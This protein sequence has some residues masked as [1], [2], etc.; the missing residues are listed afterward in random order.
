MPIALRILLLTL[1]LPAC[2]KNIQADRENRADG[3]P[4]ASS[5]NDRD[6]ASES[7]G[8]GMVAGDAYV[9]SARCGS[10]HQAEF[11]S[12][13]NSHH[14]LAMREASPDTVRGDFDD[15]R[16][17]YF[18]TVSRFFKKDGDYFVRTDGPDG[19][20]HDYPVAYTF[21][22]H[23]LQQYLVEF[24]GGRL[25]VLSIAWDSRD[26][27]EGGQRWF[28]LYPDEQVKH[29]DP[30]HWTGIDQNWNFTCADCHSTNLQKNYDQATQAYS[31]AWS[32]I[33]VACEACHGPGS[34]H[35]R[36]TRNPL[37]ESAHKGFPVSF[38]AR[39]Q[40]A[41]AM[42]TDSGIARPQ[43]PIDTRAEIE[44][45]AQC[46]SRRATRFPGAG[47]GD[48]LLDHFS[49]AVLSEPLYHAD[50]QINGEVYVYGSFLQSRMHAAGVTCSNCH[51][52]HSLQLRA[53]GNALC[54]QC[55]L[56][57][58]FDTPEHHFHPASGPG[59]HCVDCHMP[60][61][62]YMQVDARRDHSFRIPRPDLSDRLETPNACIGCHTDKPNRWAA[63]LLE[64]KFGKPAERHYGE[65]IYAGRRG[66][67]GAEAKLLQLVSD[68]SQ[69]TIARATAVSLLPRYLSQQSAP[70]LQA[71]A[72]GDEPLLSLALAQSLE[73]VPPQIRPALAV[74]LLYEDR[75]VTA[76]LAANALAGLPMAHYPLEVKQRFARA[77][78][79]Y[80]SA[81]QFN[82]DRPESLV[83]LA[84]LRAQRGEFAKAE[85]LYREAIALAPDYSPAYVNLAD[86]YRATG[87]EPRAEALLRTAL[88]A[89]ADKPAIQHALGLSL[90]RQRKTPEAMDFLRLSAEGSA[91]TGR[92]LYVYA[93]ALNST[94]KPRDA[95]FVL[96][97]GLQRF[98]D[99]PEILQG[100]MSLHRDQGNLAQAQRY[101]QRLLR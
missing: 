89:A 15:A 41:W 42:D 29:G 14:D 85:D 30:L 38:A 46:H 86:L 52:P 58:K 61:K 9:G 51:E 26:K 49:P 43:R 53:P 1:L 18:G 72:R 75:R 98:P 88:K 101:Q 13:R 32:E 4:V 92:Y 78:D 20:P 81:E 33:N 56:P 31:T 84:G 3:S 94:G 64:R 65:A 67:P 25:Q 80:L 57:E 93:I 87:R 19:K 55:H 59:A 100:L 50:G 66:L 99:D 27:S 34:R 23:P 54:A 79:D 40:A 35:L 8:P 11:Q 60:A 70:L 74:P 48:S 83:N 45:C 21:G 76:S 28:H 73:T 95:I 2:D 77:L 16:F 17:S 90:V 36:W 22:I 47:A 44:T 12:W 82:A 69:P 5:A 96:E 24:P 91:A 39:K 68:T 63:T 97:Q 7:S 6:A 37:A 71:V 62:T 10:C